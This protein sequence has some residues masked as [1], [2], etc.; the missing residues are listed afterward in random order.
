[1]ELKLPAPI[2]AAIPKKVR[3]LTLN[4]LFNPCKC[5]SPDASESDKIFVRDLR[6]KREFIIKKILTNQNNRNQMGH[7]YK[8]HFF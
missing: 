2:I 6:L 1:M 4:T 5:I 7:L 8:D 3:S